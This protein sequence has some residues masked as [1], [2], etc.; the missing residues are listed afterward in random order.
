VFNQELRFPMRLPRIGTK[1]GG[2]VFYDAGN[3]FSRLGT[4][5]FRTSPT[6]AAQNSGE[7]SYF[8]HT[9]GIGFRYATPIGPVR[10]DLAYQLNA[11]QFFIPCTIGNPGC[12]IT[13]TQLTRLPRFQF[14]FNLG[15]VF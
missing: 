12:G 14:F 15:D 9:V 5:T 3:V 8:S 7:L 4:I 6:A 1:L 13:G 11:A 2:A 10:V